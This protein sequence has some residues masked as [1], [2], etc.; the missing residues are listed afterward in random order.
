MARADEL[1][2]RYAQ[3]DGL[4]SFYRSVTQFQSRVFAAFERS[5]DTDVASLTRYR[6]DLLRLV[7]REGPRQLVDFARMLLPTPGA[8]EGLLRRCWE[9]D[10]LK[11]PGPEEPAKFFARALLQPFAE[12]LAS[13]GKPD[14]GETAST[15]PFCGARPVAGVLRSEGDGAKRSLLCSLCATEWAFRRILCPSCGEEDKERLPVFESG[16]FDLVR[17]EA[18]DTCKTYIKTVSLTKNGHAVPMVDELAAPALAI[19]ADEMGY[20][21]LETNILGM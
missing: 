19:W 5:G 14:G 16:E 12:Y 8:H 10:E 2:A 11:G 21:R 3:S 20:S 18:C 4:L 15:C 17:L 9:T 7:E 1:R 6:Q 13:R